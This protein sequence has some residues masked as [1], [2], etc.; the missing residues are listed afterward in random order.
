[1]LSAAYI[2]VEQE[3]IVT[4][5][6]IAFSIFTR[7]WC[8]Q[9]TFSRSRVATLLETDSRSW[10]T[11]LARIK[12]VDLI[13]FLSDWLT[14]APDNAKARI[15]PRVWKM[16]GF[17]FIKRFWN[18]K[19]TNLRMYH[20]PSTQNVK[21]VVYL[22]KRSHKRFSPRL[23]SEVSNTCRRSLTKRSASDSQSMGR[24]RNNS[25]EVSKNGPCRGDP[26]RSCAFST[27][28]LLV[29]VT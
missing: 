1:M 4:V 26:N 15:P 22:R 8:T 9:N 12:D 18:A 13:Q 14:Y 25:G 20:P 6:M 29:F 3:V 28:P 16:F 19:V 5:I 27:S 24:N 11:K 17:Y 23:W 10:S 21:M 7:F 2:P